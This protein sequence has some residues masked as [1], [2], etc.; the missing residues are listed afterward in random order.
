[1]NA[2]ELVQSF[3]I[4]SAFLTT[5]ILRLSASIVLL[6]SFDLRSTDDQT[7][8][9]ILGAILLGTIV[10]GSRKASGFKLCTS[11]TQQAQVSSVHRPGWGLAGVQQ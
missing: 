6:S 2:L 11:Y 8:I 7:A 10:I 3:W 9:G 1:M 5:A 4:I